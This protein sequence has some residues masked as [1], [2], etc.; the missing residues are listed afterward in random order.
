MGK[1]KISWGDGIVMKTFHCQEHRQTQD[2]PWMWTAMRVFSTV[3]QGERKDTQ[4]PG[5]RLPGYSTFRQGLLTS[6]LLCWE[7]WAEG[8]EE[9]VK[10]DFKVS[11][12]TSDDSAETQITSV[13][14]TINSWWSV[15][16]ILL[17]SHISTCTFTSLLKR[18]ETN[19]KTN[20]VQQQQQNNH[21]HPWK[22]QNK[23]KQKQK[24][25]VGKERSWQRPDGSQGRHS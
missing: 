12:L 4:C 1:K 13:T 19:K 5:P 2:A 14:T 7:K 10:V 22:K 25:A 11:P 6:L 24:T 15:Q 18:K 23:T 17:L 3:T 8:A 16:K 9:E 21:H 20:N